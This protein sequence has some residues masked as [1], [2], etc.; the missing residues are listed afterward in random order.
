MNDLSPVFLVGFPRSGTTL[1]ERLIGNGPNVR[2]SDELPTMRA[3]ME[4]FHKITGSAY[5]TPAALNQLTPDDI[6][7]L[8]KDYR[9]S[10]SSL[11]PGA[12]EPHTVFINKDPMSIV[13]L[14]LIAHMFPA[15]PLLLMLRDPATFARAVS[16]RSLRSIAP[17]ICCPTPATP[18]HYMGPSWA[19]AGVRAGASRSNDDCSL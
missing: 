3:A 15:S 14:P 11:I 18:S 1:L 10:V 16:R 4:R 2:I 19:L 6:N 5:L 12:L 7:Q 13:N 9:D 8:R 17:P